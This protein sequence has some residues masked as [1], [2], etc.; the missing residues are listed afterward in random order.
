MSSAIQPHA[1]ARA[2]TSDGSDRVGLDSS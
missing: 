2:G 1:S